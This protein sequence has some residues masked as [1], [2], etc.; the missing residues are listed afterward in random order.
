[1]PVCKNDKFARYT[2]KE[3]SPKGL[4]YC[5]HQEKEGKR[6]KG[7]DGNMWIVRRINRQREGSILR[8]Q[9]VK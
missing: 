4:G 1:M 8:W 9:R 2:G 5:A 7:R 3:P 6:R